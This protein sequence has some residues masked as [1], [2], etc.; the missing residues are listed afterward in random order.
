VPEDQD[1]VEDG[2]A[3]G[4]FDC[5]LRELINCEMEDREHELSEANYISTMVAIP[6]WNWLRGAE[7]QSWP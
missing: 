2:E 5:P 4:F 1:V 3:R 7:K 6:L